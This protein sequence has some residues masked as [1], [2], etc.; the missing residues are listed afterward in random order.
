MFYILAILI[1]MTLIAVVNI[2]VNSLY[3]NFEIWYIIVAVIVNTVAVIA[4]D[5]LFATIIR[6]ML[7]N[8]WFE[9]RNLLKVSKKECFFYEKIG[10]KR[11]KEKV[12]EL[13]IFA[14]FR[15]NKIAEPTNNEYIARYILEINYGVFVHIACV[16]FGF[17][18]VF[19][20]P[21][22]YFLCFGIPVAVVNAILNALPIF[23]LR[24]N[25]PKLVR[26]YELN[27]RRKAIQEQNKSEAV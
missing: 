5:G 13:G 26:L 11:W 10:I 24:Y 9:K 18:I 7:P 27:E 25:L 15:K 2:L 20:Y 22:Q 3:F 21:L 8:K 17:V 14:N 4:V 6:H 23:V 12:I 19:F 16:I 1:S